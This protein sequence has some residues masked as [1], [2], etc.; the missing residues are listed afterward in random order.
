MNLWSLAAARL[1]D[2]NRKI[3]DFGTTV[4]MQDLLSSVK[5]SKDE[6]QRKQWVVNSVVLRDTFSKIAVWI[7]KFI[8]VGDIAI[9]TT[10]DM[11][12]FRGLLYDSFSWC[13]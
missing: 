2:K 1:R 11:L 6:C 9:N 13:V 4:D 3:L 7:Q 5:D 12:R 10:L 8:D